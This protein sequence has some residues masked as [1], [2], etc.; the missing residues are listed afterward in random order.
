LLLEHRY[1][2]TVA[3]AEAEIRAVNSTADQAR[4]LAVKPGTSAILLDRTV[5]DSTGRPIEFARDLYRA[6]RASFRVGA[7]LSLHRPLR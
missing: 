3:R 5:V 1:A 2:I 6:D 4:L 7:D